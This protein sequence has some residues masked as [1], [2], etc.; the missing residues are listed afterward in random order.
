MLGVPFAEVGSATRSVSIS[1]EL[2]DPG[3]TSNPTTIE[4]LFGKPIQVSRKAFICL[5]SLVAVSISS[6]VLANGIGS[7]SSS[8]FP[9][10]VR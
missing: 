1:N 7:R 9:C 8:L 10:K 6:S 2:V 3:L 4:S 5:F